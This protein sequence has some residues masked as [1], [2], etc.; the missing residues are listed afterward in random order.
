MAWLLYTTILNFL[1]GKIPNRKC[2]FFPSSRLS[3]SAWGSWDCSRSA[4]Q[5][6]ISCDRTANG[7]QNRRTSSTTYDRESRNHKTSFH[8]LV[9]I[10]T[11]D[12]P[13]KT[14][15]YSSNRDW[16]QYI[17][18][19]I[20]GSSTRGK[21]TIHAHLLIG[22]WST[23]KLSRHYLIINLRSRIKLGRMPTTAQQQLTTGNDATHDQQTATGCSN[24]RQASAPVI[25]VTEASEAC[26]L[27]PITH[28]PKA[29]EA[30]SSPPITHQPKASEA[31]SS[32]PITHQPKA[33][34]ACSLL[35]ITHQPKA[36]EACSLLPIT[37]QPKASE[38]RFIS[39]PTNHSSIRGQRGQ[40]IYT[41]H[42]SL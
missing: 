17:E 26:S 30:R 20:T 5:P 23:T 24:A 15:I 39:I 18:G 19:V 1:N 27:L 40:V 34:E 35:P 14:V 29:S 11:G 8:L 25:H 42:S 6:A 31:R 4:K 12:V 37:H 13:A 28:Q 2:L 16:R 36:S 3:C 33:S 41:N 32:P 10:V 38:A 7:K 21:R 22:L 9:K